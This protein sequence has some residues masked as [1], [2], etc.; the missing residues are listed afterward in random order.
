MDSQRAPRRKARVV[1]AWI[2]VPGKQGHL[3]EGKEKGNL[4][5]AD[6]SAGRCGEIGSDSNCT[7]SRKMLSFCRRRSL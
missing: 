3:L 5:L 6:Y 1:L 7:Q 4:N 2:S